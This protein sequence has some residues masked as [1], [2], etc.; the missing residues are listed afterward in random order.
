MYHFTECG[1]DYVWLRNGFARKETPRGVMTKI[2]NIDGLHA[3]IGQW[4]VRNPA[5]IR[6]REVR[7]LRSMLGLSQHTMARLLGQSRASVARWEGAPDVSIPAGSDRWLRIVYTKRAQ[8]DKA[9]CELVD[10]LTDLDLLPDSGASD[11][12]DAKFKDDDGWRSAP[13][14]FGH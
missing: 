11:S 9:V 1:L 6:G 7:F 8:G 12:R 2:Q 14:R 3:A 5:C 13:L 10:L 4:I